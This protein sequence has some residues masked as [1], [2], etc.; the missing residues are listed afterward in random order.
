MSLTIDLCTSDDV[1]EL[2]PLFA[3]YLDFYGREQPEDS[4]AEFLTARLAAGDS[5][6][7]L[8]R[9]DGQA[10]GFAQNYP[11]WSSLS[12]A[13]AWTFND[14]F[15]TPEG[16][17]HG[18]GRRLLQA[19]CDAARDAGAT[20]IALETAPDNAP[21]RSL[22]EDEGFDLDNEFMHYSKSFAQS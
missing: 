21:A 20:Y 17:R 2:V 15:V 6:I 18:A 12:L 13:P 5:V 10:V 16:R 11:T 14:L 1:V 3:G 19:S 4:V 9:V 7:L 22:Y 8:A